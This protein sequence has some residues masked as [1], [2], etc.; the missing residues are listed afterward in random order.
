[1]EFNNC[2][3]I[4]PEIGEFK[5]NLGENALDP[6]ETQQPE[7]GDIA[8]KLLHPLRAD[9]L[10]KEKWRL[11]AVELLPTEP[12]KL[13]VRLLDA[14]TQ[15]E[16]RVELTQ[17]DASRPCYEKSRSFNMSFAS[18]GVTTL[19]LEDEEALVQVFDAIHENDHG[20]YVFEK[21]PD[22]AVKLTENAVSPRGGLLAR[23]KRIFGKS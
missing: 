19:P 16:I 23:L 9:D 15:R 4:E 13:V 6:N 12:P 5:N 7:T 3:R 8:W 18:E 21:T 17:L 22:G 20:R 10:L 14:E 1:M 2:D 11:N